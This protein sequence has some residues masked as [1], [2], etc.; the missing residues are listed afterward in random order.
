[1]LR[2]NCFTFFCLI[3]MKTPPNNWPISNT[4]F[5]SQESAGQAPIFIEQVIKN[6]QDTLYL[7]LSLSS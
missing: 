3:E 6:I 5:E 7:N 1:M 2:C 4:N